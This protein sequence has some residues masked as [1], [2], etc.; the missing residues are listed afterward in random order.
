MLYAESPQIRTFSYQIGWP[1]NFQRHPHFECISL[2][3]LDHGRLA[4]LRARYILQRKRFDLVIMLH[5]VFSNSCHLKGRFFDEICALSQPKVYFIGNEY[6]LMPEKMAFCDALELAL[7][8]TMLP[9]PKAQALYRQ[10]LG[11]E[12]TH[13]PQAALDRDL[14]FP[15]TNRSDR[16]IDLGFR[17]VVDPRPI[18]HDE[19]QR[20]AG[21]FSERAPFY[22]LRLDVSLEAE[23]RFDTAGWAAFLNRCKGQL[24]TE[25]GTDFFELTDATRHRVNEYLRSNPDATADEIYPRFFA[26]Q[27]EAISGRTIGGRHVD[28]AGTKTVQILFNG[29]YSGYFQPD[30][31]YIPLQKD[32]GNFDDVIAKFRDEE[33]CKKIVENAHSVVIRELTYEK[34]LD[35]FYETVRSVT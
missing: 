9:T 26:G 10:R 1:R 32:F 35:G 33:Y 19:R 27:S 3:V 23:D 20:I 34:L 7:F 24:G 17:S 11:C 16:E 15:A 8:V 29:Y 25:A 4:R 30:V 14:F 28:A 22:G 5:S 12:I 13:I 31:H 6:K 2:N 18:G 21:V